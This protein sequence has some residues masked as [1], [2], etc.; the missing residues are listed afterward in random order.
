M[1]RKHKIHKV[2]NEYEVIVRHNGKNLA[3]KVKV[4]DSV[5]DQF[6]QD[7]IDMSVHRRLEQRKRQE[8]MKELENKMWGV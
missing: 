3:I 5:K 1:A 7:F 2:G 8:K 6:T 4:P